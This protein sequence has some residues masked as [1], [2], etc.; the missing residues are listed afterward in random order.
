MQ[1]RSDVSLL[2][3]DEG[4]PEA[5][6]SA[7]ESGRPS[8]TTNMKIIADMEFFDAMNSL[9]FFDALSILEIFESLFSLHWTLRQRKQ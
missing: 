8:H 6:Q 9:K 5:A 3:F 1:V 4:W 2:E 7:A